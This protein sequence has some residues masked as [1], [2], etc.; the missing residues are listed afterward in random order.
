MAPKGKLLI[1]GGHEE[2]GDEEESLNVVKRVKGYEPFEI[3]GSLINKTAGSETIIEIITSASSV[4]EEIEEWY[5]EAYKREGFHKIGFLHM[6]KWTR[7]EETVYLERIKK[8]HAVFFTGGDQVKLVKTIKGSEILKAVIKKYQEDEQFILAGTSAGA[9]SLSD[10][11]IEDGLIGEVLFKD[12]LQIGKGFGLISNMIVDTHFIQRGRFA[13][14]AQAVIQ[15]P[16]C[17]GIGLS[18][19]TSLLISGENEAECKGSGMVIIIDAS[20]MGQNNGND[21]NENTA[22][23]AENL[24]VHILADSCKFFLKDKKF[25]MA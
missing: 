11:I 15:N 23:V 17:L 24:T 6:D 19:N 1:I 12:D 5:L 4:P 13:R 22:I 2:K 25:V 18:E 3:L 8:A 7:D 16:S 9:M 10:I 20:K 14:L 21:A